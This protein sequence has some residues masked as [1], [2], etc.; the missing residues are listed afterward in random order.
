MHDQP[1]HT[2]RGESFSE[3][4]GPLS[5]APGAFPLLATTATISIGGWAVCEVGGH[6]RGEGYV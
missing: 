6:A 3:P 4:R 1:C 5:P 2:P